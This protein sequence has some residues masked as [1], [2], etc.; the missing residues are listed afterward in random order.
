MYSGPAFVIHYKY[1]FV[2]NVSFC[3]FLFGPGMPIL[4]PIAWFAVFLQYTME[5][6]MMAYS[7]RKP[8]MYDSQINRDCLMILR[9]APILY[10]FSAAWTFS[11]Q[12][13]F[14]GEVVY[15]VNDY[16][17][18]S[19]NHTA[20]QLWKQISP[21]S[22][23]A[24][25]VTVFIFAGLWKVLR[26]CCCKSETALDDEILYQNLEPFYKSLTPQTR[27]N[28]LREAVQ[29]KKRLDMPKLST[30]SFTR[31]A[32]FKDEGKSEKAKLRG[33]HNY[34]MLANSEYANLFHYI[35][36]I[37]PSRNDYVISEYVDKDMR[38]K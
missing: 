17:Y 24:I 2:L 21:A 35:P 1:S 37:Y 14:F 9:F 19:T 7:Y 31:L 25:P 22:V 32:K 29:N 23:Y 13:V 38:M 3:A 33:V 34:D 36:C 26:W 15:D 10:V 27:E 6:L 8:V 5:R 4:F 18:A 28:W 30:E 16:L 20:K 12:Q 11:N